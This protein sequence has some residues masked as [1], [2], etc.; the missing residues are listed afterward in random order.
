MGG[1]RGST[2]QISLV[3]CKSGQGW[4]RLGREKGEDQNLKTADCELSLINHRNEYAGFSLGECGG[5]SNWLKY[6][7][8]E[9]EANDPGGNIGTL[10][11]NSNTC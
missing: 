6:D 1:S 10:G 4:T 8:C 7:A 11:I 5:E 2:K 9:D 3:V